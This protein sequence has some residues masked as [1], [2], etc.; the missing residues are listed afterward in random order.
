MKKT[1]QRGIQQQ[2][3]DAIKDS[4]RM[5][6]ECITKKEIITQVQQKGLKLKQPESQVGQA[7]YQLQRTTKFRQPRIQ[8]VK[9][10]EKTG[11]AIIDETGLY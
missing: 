1:A 10:D 8:K 4:K 9:T 5:H 2:V 7:L 11:W 3:L 6:Y